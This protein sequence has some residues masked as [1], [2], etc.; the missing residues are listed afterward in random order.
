M[1]RTN[2]ARC[3]SARGQLFEVMFRTPMRPERELRLLFEVPSP[4]ILAAML[5]A[6]HYGIVFADWVDADH[7][8]ELLA[9][10]AEY[11]DAARA[12]AMEE[13]AAGKKARKP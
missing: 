13:F 6:F 9:K 10:S 8:A 2:K 5:A 1:E 4:A 11:K 12:L 3:E 7:M